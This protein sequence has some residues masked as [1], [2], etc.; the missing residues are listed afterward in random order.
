MSAAYARCLRSPPAFAA[1]V[2]S[3]RRRSALDSHCVAAGI[4]GQRSA[5][6]GTVGMGLVKLVFESYAL[7]SD[8]RSL[9]L[10]A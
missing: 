8:H 6:L 7:L 4:I 5:I 3:H 1:C 2:R 10:L 9:N